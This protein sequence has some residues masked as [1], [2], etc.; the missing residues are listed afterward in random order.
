MVLMMQRKEALFIDAHYI[1]R[2]LPDMVLVVHNRRALGV[3]PM[4]VTCGGAL[5][6]R[7]LSSPTA[8]ALAAITHFL[9]GLMPLHLGYS[10]LHDKVRSHLTQLLVTLWQVFFGCRTKGAISRCGSKCFAPLALLFACM[11]PPAVR[12]FA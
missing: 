6:A 11:V 12:E 2:A 10:P 9:A 7:Q 4:G 3:H 8:A 5:V 1:A